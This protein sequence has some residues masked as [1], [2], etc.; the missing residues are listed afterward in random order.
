MATKIIEVENDV[1]RKM[2]ARNL[3]KELCKN[4]KETGREKRD[5]CKNK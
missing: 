1:D 5:K 3:T 2:T 4:R